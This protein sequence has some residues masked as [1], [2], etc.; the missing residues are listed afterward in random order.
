MK[1]WK[2]EA[3]NGNIKEQ[4]LHAQNDYSQTKDGL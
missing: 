4:V 2:K 1:D 3:T